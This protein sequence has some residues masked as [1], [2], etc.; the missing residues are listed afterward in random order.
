[1]VKSGGGWGR[2]K[3]DRGG[4]GRGWM[5]LEDCEKGWVVLEEGEGRWVEGE[6]GL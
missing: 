3:G 5:T 6:G 2:L 4:G 1:M